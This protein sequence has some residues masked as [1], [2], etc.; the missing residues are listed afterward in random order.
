MQHT[1]LLCL[2]HD[3]LSTNQKE[4]LLC[5]EITNELWKNSFNE[6]FNSKLE[7]CTS[8]LK[9]TMAVKFL[10]NARQVLLKCQ[11]NDD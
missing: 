9:A 2:R 11:Q 8:V 10:F 5:F 6:F 1:N 7:V 4:Q 3:H